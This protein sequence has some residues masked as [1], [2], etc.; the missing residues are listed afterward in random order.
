MKLV[1]IIA[2]FVF[3]VALA[4]NSCNFTAS[5]VTCAAWGWWL[6][7]I[8]GGITLVIYSLVPLIA[9]IGGAVTGAEVAKV[10]GAVIGFLGGMAGGMLLLIIPLFI[11]A[12]TIGLG[13]FG[14]SALETAATHNFEVK[15]EVI[16][17]CVLLGLSVLLSFFLSSS[18]SSSKKS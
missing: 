18:S 6:S 7:W 13:I 14:Y 12:C 17:C 10:P 2:I 15:G 11:V 9:S 1:H 3:V 16:K 5:A 4:F 8:I